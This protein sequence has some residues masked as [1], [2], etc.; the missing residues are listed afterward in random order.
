MQPPFPP[1]SVGMGGGSICHLCRQ[2][3]RGRV[4][5]GSHLCL[6]QEFFACGFFLLVFLLLLV[7]YYFSTCSINL[8]GRCRRCC[9]NVSLHWCRAHSSLPCVAQHCARDSRACLISGKLVC[10]SMKDAAGE[11]SLMYC[12]AT[13]ELAKIPSKWFAF[14]LK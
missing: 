2:T 4:T 14:R 11:M 3:E 5:Q 8:L 10:Q 7:F 12:E 13:E 9:G 1:V 6:F